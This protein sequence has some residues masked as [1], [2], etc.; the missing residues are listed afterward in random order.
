MLVLI[1]YS[2]EARPIQ[3]IVF[4]LF[5][6]MAG[7][8][9]TLSYIE[10]IIQKSYASI[11]PTLSD[12]YKP[13]PPLIEMGPQSGKDGKRL[14]NRRPIVVVGQ[15]LLLPIDTS[16]QA[17]GCLYGD[18]NGQ[19]SPQT[20]Q[21]RSYLFFPEIGLAASSFKTANIPANSEES[22]LCGRYSSLKSQVIQNYP[23][24]CDLWLHQIIE[25]VMICAAEDVTGVQSFLDKLKS[26]I[27][28]S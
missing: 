21:A 5:N 19:P 3:S 26:K 9:R 18:G 28:V 11:P 10:V 16:I 17:P 6:S 24:R 7:N 15:S 12:N 25:A 2:F 13:T 14:N 23:D 1:F 4:E 20:A 8:G 22:Y 27:D